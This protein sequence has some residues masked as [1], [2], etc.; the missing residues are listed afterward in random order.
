MK[1]PKIFFKKIY[2]SAL[3]SM[4]FTLIFYP[5]YSFYHTE[6][7]VCCEILPKTKKRQLFSKIDEKKNPLGVSSSKFDLF[8]RFSLT[9]YF[10]IN[11]CLFLRFSN[12][13]FLIKNRFFYLK[14]YSTNYYTIKLIVYC[15][16]LQ[17]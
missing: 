4:S 3:L 5:I 16:K 10:N 2:F 11:A 17:V 13:T 9:L 7:A 6:I 12:L 8:Y 14:S 1:I 15:H